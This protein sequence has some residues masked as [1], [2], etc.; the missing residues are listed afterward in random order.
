[1]KFYHRIFL[2]NT[3]LN[4]DKWIEESEIQKKLDPRCGISRIW[5]FT[6]QKPLYY[7]RFR[8][9]YRCW[10]NDHIVQETQHYTLFLNYPDPK[11]SDDEILCFIANFFV[12]GYND[13]P[14]KRHYW[15]SN[16]DMKNYSIYN[17]MIRYRFLQICRFLQFAD[18][19]K[20]NPND[21]TW[22]IHRLLEMLKNRCLKKFVPEKQLSYDEC[23][24]KY[25]EN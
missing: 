5:L 16:D 9:I 25:F 21:K 17:A 19:S 6:I 20:M 3:H 4:L 12:S 8:E 23:M 15:D 14:S 7:R 13:L 18:N 22:K 24:I 11:I 2:T 1:M 10:N